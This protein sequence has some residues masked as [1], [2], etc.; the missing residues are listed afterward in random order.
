MG[1]DEKEGQSSQINE[2]QK[3]EVSVP[4][5]QQGPPP[6][7]PNRSRP[8]CSYCNDVGHVRAT[9]WKLNPHLKTKRQGS[10]P[11]AKAAAVQLVQ[12]PDFYGV[13]GQDHHTAGGAPPTASIAGRGSSHQ[14]ANWAGVSEGQIVPSGSDIRW[15]ETRNTVPHRF[16]FDF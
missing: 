10:H 8:Q 14:G 15:G 11:K 6:G 4:F 7:F 16:D 3:V 9:C 13:A 1:G 5:H 2:V 12:E